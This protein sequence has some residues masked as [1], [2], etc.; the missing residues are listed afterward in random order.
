MKT[1]ANI[2]VVAS[3]LIY[4]LNLFLTFVWTFEKRS[5]EYHLI[6]YPKKKRKETRTRNSDNKEEKEGEGEGERRACGSQRTTSQR[7]LASFS[8]MWVLGLELV[9]SGLAA[10]T[11]T[12]WPVFRTL[13]HSW[14]KPDSKLYLYMVCHYLFIN[15]FSFWDF[16][17]YS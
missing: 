1:C 6:M 15:T 4:Y 13:D 17:F 11:R 3:Y 8:R 7:C 9:L 5:L 2:S 14:C 16:N 12:P 10:N